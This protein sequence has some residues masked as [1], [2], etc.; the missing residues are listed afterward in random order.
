MTVGKGRSRRGRGGGRGRQAACSSFSP[1]GLRKRR[2][3]RERDER[4]AADD[5]LRAGDAEGGGK[6]PGGRSRLAA[7]VNR[8]SAQLIVFLYA[9]SQCVAIVTFFLGV[10]CFQRLFS[11]LGDATSFS[12][13]AVAVELANVCT[14]T[15]YLVFH[16]GYRGLR[17]AFAPPHG[18]SPAR[19]HPRLASSI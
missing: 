10:M 8:N 4:R 18:A 5:A 6:A 13:S 12:G 15:V 7:H 11:R 1:M 9:W 2:E 3:R 16:I 14:L 19:G 17:R